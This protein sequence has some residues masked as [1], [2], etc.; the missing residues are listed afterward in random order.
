MASVTSITV[1]LRCDL[2]EQVARLAQASD[3]TLDEAVEDALEL[4]LG[5][6]RSMPNIPVVGAK[7]PDAT[8]A[9]SK[10]FGEPEQV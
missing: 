6:D 3:L 8:P 4:W 10:S 1:E 7:K 2:A 9:V 5:Y